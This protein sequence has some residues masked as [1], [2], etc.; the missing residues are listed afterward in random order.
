MADS[1]LSIVLTGFAEAY[2]NA[3]NAFT[4]RHILSIIAPQIDYKMLSMFIPGLTRYR[5]TAARTHAA[6]F[7]QGSILMK[8]HRMI[9][10][11]DLAQ[12]DHFVEFLISSHICID[13]PFG[14]KVLKLSN[15]TILHVPNT[16]RSLIPT[17]II[18]Q[19]YLYCQQSCPTF[20]PLSSS[21]L[22]KLLDV[23]KA[24][25][26]QAFQGLNNFVA[27]GSAA[28]TQLYKLV[29]GLAIDANE[30]DRIIT[31]LKRA[32]QYLKTDYKVHI[33]RSSEIADHCILYAL[34]EKKS[35]WFSS[36]CDH[37]HK[38]LCIECLNM[39]N[40]FFDVKNV[41]R[42]HA[43]KKFMDRIMY[44]FD[45]SVDAILTWKA[46]LL[47]CINQD[48]CRTKIMQN[49]SSRDVYMNLDWAMK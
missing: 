48:L 16:I 1:K 36:S 49:L 33:S 28:F 47:R 26:R 20:T 40:T 8:P 17:R 7:G 34:N 29:D 4:R 11:F 9:E 14:Q 10:R 37:E 32:K 45:E 41:I 15:G 35:Q 23:C 21:S 5:Y 30:K 38:Y 27:N 6:D 2:K 18:S 25:T 3:E 22:F 44:D 43:S 13:M 39:R 42:E 31:S 24:S 46:H 19:Y 12:V